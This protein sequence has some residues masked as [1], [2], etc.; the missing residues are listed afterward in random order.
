[1]DYTDIYLRQR[2]RDETT[3]RPPTRPVEMENVPE[4]RVEH[5]LQGAFSVQQLV[6]QIEELSSRVDAFDEKMVNL[7]KL[8]KLAQGLQEEKE[9]DLRRQQQELRSRLK[10]QEQV[11]SR[12]QEEVDTLKGKVPT[13]IREAMTEFRQEVVNDM[14]QMRKQSEEQ[15]R[16]MKIDFE[17]RLDS[18]R[19]GLEQSVQTTQKEAST[20]ATSH[21][22][23]QTALRERLCLIEKTLQAL[24]AS[25]VNEYS[26]LIPLETNIQHMSE[27]LLSLQEKADGTATA[28][29]A[30]REE[31]ERS[32]GVMM[33]EMES[34]R[35][36][37]TRNLQR[38]KQHVEALSMDFAQ[39]RNEQVDFSARLN[40]VSCQA[41]VEY[42][43]LRALLLQKAREADALCNMVG[44]EMGK[45]E[46][47]AEK[48][49]ALRSD[50]CAL[51]SM[52]F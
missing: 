24:E 8:V 4:Q 36:W 9:T 38:V 22:E 18:V 7:T 51:K 14:T 35:Q 13:S 33:D 27:S 41:D 11:M 31:R 40:R 6:N 15:L 19:R 30:L 52:A 39:L 34:T 48:H 42:K 45:V 17:R 50:S 3:A 12:L 37:A 5:M 47:M 28:V 46:D 2:R 44:K 29:S 49:Q 32:Q 23:A 16:D 1:M 10:R 20:M 26:R 25:T 21:S 43:K